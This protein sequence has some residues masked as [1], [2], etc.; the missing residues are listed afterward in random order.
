MENNP[1]YYDWNNNIS[2]NY[3][4]TESFLMS[5]FLILQAIILVY[6]FY[7]L[8][9]VCDDYF[10]DSLEIITKKLKISDDVAG[11]SFMAIGSSA[12]E[13]FIA[14]IALGKVGAESVGVGTIVGS[15][16]FNVLVIVGASAWVST[17]LLNWRP[18]LRDMLFYII[19]LLIL[20]FTFSD[21]IITLYEVLFYLAAYIV[22]LLVLKK[23]KKWVPEVR[24]KERP[25]V[26]MDRESEKNGDIETKKR[27]KGGFVV[28][29]T[30]SNRILSFTYYKSKEN[31]DL[32]I[33]SFLMSIVW[34]AFL[35]WAMVEISMEMANE[36][37]IPVA[38][39]GITVLA[40]GTSV[41]DLI[42]SIIASK[43]GLGNM[44]VSNALGSNTF[45]ILIGLG[46][47]WLLY[48]VIEGGN[49]EVET[50]TLTTSI[51]LLFGSVVL[52][53]FLFLI[54]RFEISKF[55]GGLL[56]FIY[57]AYLFVSIMHVI[58]NNYFASLF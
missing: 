21:G 30:V 49:I 39:I 2:I 26:V 56:I 54:K 40:A 24:K 14:L 5:S 51:M 15:A 43:R 53:L 38:I 22:Y 32:Y 36:I 13:L 29:E 33:Y 35:S 19:S 25:F 12:P 45:D 41:P 58:D 48:I 31:E 8:A 4:V 23:W 3:F 55:T 17:I 9:K 44:A 57:I 28:V 6:I 47:P 7:L 20:I 34:I 50:G 46:I 1:Y 11:A 27:K 18:V 37:G 16:V 52:L 10:V 42:S